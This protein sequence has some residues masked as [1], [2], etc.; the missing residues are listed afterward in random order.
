MEESRSRILIIGKPKSGKLTLA[1]GNPRHSVLIE[2]ELTGSLPEI[3]EG[4]TSHASLSHEFK[5]RNKYYSADVG[6]W[7]DEFEDPDQLKPEQDPNQENV[8]KNSPESRISTVARWA[9]EFCSDE[10]REVRDVLGAVIFTFDKFEEEDARQVKLFLDK[11]NDEDWDGL[12]LAVSKGDVEHETAC[13]DTLEELGFDYIQGTTKRPDDTSSDEYH[14]MSGIEQVK[15]ALEV[16]PWTFAQKELDDQGELGPEEPGPSLNF[17][18]P[19]KSTALE[20]DISSS[21]SI[22]MAAG[23]S[24]TQSAADATFEDLIR[25]MSTPILAEDGGSEASV[26]KFD[27]FLDKLRRARGEF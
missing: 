7:I 17:T 12:A 26:D 6:I 19:A 8:T 9:Q 16:V 11:L 23:P 1:K 21:T 22:D 20:Q 10:A 13:I 4:A 27:A 5:I 25:N 15:Q 18:L 3:E 14:D 2:T 24:S